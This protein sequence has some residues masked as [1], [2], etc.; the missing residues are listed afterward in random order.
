MMNQPSLE[1]VDMTLQMHILN[2]CNLFNVTKEREVK[3]S[4]S[5]AIHKLIKTFRSLFFFGT[6]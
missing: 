5:Y 3:L 6:T 4:M 2:N 1:K